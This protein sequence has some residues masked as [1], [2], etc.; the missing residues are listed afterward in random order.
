MFRVKPIIQGY[1]CSQETWQAIIFE[2][3]QTTRE[4]GNIYD[5]YVVAII[6]SGV[7][8]IVKECIPSPFWS[9]MADEATDVSTTEQL[10]MCVC[11]VRETRTGA[12]EVCEEFLGFSSIPAIGAEDITSAIVAL[13]SACWLNMARLVEKG[14][15]RASNMSTHMSGISARLK[16]LHPNARYL[17]HCCNHTLSL[18][19]VA[20]C[21]NVPD[22]RNFMDT[23]KA[24]TLFFNYSAKRKHIF[25]EHLKSSAQED[26]LADCVAGHLV[27]AKK[28]YEKFQ[29]FLTHDGRQVLTALTAFSRTTE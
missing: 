8:S 25:R 1:Y 3:L 11:Y 29:C 17:T 12:I 19:I 5:L 6:R 13:S 28:R 16:E 23:L 24:L 20:S 21:N 15:D 14:F 26:F 2:E 10:S 4:V 7:T 9:V 22:V 27:P 18:V